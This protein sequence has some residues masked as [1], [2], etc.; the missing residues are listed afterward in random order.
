LEAALIQLVVNA[1]H[2]AYGLSML[3]RFDFS[4]FKKFYCIFGMTDET[5]ALLSSLPENNERF[6]QV[7]GLTQLIPAADKSTFMF[8]VTLLDHFYW[9]FG[10][11]IGAIAGSLIPFNSGG[12]GF[13]LTALFIVLMLEQ[14]LKVRKP[15]IFV[16]SAILAVLGVIFLPSRLSLLAALTLSLA[17]CSFNR[18][19]G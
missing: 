17:A 1:R 6:I 18:K 8:L 2:I 16:I 14:M 4:G 13:A 9:V 19:N 5:Y 3:T 15:G 12:I 7:P 10:T 11:F